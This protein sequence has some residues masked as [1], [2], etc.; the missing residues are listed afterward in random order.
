[1]KSGSLYSATYHSR[2][3]MVNCG[4]IEAGRAWGRSTT[5]SVSECFGRT[6]MLDHRWRG[7]IQERDTKN[8][9][10]ITEIWYTKNIRYNRSSLRNHIEDDGVAIALEGT[11]QASE[12]M[13]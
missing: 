8:L 9:L 5:R 3:S 10:V 11:N 6:S 13:I 2:R 12:V 4:L 7:L 1:M